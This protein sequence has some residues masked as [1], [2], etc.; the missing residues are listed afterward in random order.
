[1]EREG[2]APTAM[3]GGHRGAGE[4]AGGTGDACD[5]PQGAGPTWKGGMEPLDPEGDREA[6]GQKMAG[7]P[8]GPQE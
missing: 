8:Q 3:E 5:G 4:E 2:F 7:L 6:E 1:M